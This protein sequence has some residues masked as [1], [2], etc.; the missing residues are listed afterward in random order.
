[1]VASQMRT[2]LAR[3]PWVGVSRAGDG[4]CLVSGFVVAFGAPPSCGGGGVG[5]LLRA[6]IEAWALRR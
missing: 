5:G 2:K 3:L 4:G 6:V 1:M